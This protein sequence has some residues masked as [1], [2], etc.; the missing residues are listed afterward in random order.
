MPCADGDGNMEASRRNSPRHSRS[1]RAVNGRDKDRVSDGAAAAAVD[2]ADAETASA[3]D[4]AP[5]GATAASP[6][7]ALTPT[8]AAGGLSAVAL[9]AAVVE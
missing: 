9:S 8:A 5:A 2:T 3:P 4:A 1:S 7:A 6:E